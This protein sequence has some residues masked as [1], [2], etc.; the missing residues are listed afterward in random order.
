MDT[1]TACKTPLSPVI[2]S[3]TARTC[4]PFF[5][6]KKSTEIK[7]PFVY[8]AAISALGRFLPAPSPRRAWPEWV[9]SGLIL[10]LALFFYSQYSVMNLAQLPI[11]WQDWQKLAPI[12]EELQRIDQQIGKDGMAASDFL[13][14]QMIKR[15]EVYLFPNPWKVHYWG[16]HGESPRHPNRV[17]WI[18]VAPDFRSEHQKDLLDYLTE[19]GYFTLVQSHEKFLLFHRQKREK[20]SRDEA[21]AAFHA[22]RP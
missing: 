21:I 3:S 10:G 1:L 14:P 15:Q 11:H 5:P 17:E 9:G 20:E 12:R 13:L 18:L 22:Y 4:A 19:N 6:F 2:G 16:I 8:L 7:M